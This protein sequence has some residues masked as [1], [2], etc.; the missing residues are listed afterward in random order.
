AEQAQEKGHFNSRHLEP[1][2][3]QTQPKKGNQCQTDSHSKA[4]KATSPSNRDS[5]RPQFTEIAPTG[6]ATARNH[7]AP[8][9]ETHKHYSP[10]GPNSLWSTMNKTQPNELGG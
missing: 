4:P 1:H 5:A 2:S 3:E 8:N 9:E 6:T 10:N 7:T